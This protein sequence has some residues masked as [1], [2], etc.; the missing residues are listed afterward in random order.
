MSTSTSASAELREVI[1]ERLISLIETYKMN[2]YLPHLIELAQH[3]E[4]SAA[5]YFI[6]DL[7][8]SKDS[9]VLP[10]R[11]SIEMYYREIIKLGAIVETEV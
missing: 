3:F 8:L 9:F 2:E 6:E 1:L 5:V 4:L 11:Q 10:L 7:Y